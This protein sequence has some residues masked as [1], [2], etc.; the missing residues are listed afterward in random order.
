MENQITQE[1]YDELQRQLA[2][3]RQKVEVLTTLNATDALTGIENHR[4]FNEDLKKEIGNSRRNRRKLI[5]IMFDVDY[6]KDINDTGGHIWGD[7]V[8]IEMTKAVNST[9]RDEDSFARRS[10]DEFYLLFPEESTTDLSHFNMDRY[11]EAIAK[12][13]RSKDGEFK[14]LTISIGA[15]II[16]FSHADP[17]N[18]DQNINPERLLEEVDSFLYTSKREGRDRLSTKTIVA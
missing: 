18:P 17:N 1:M 5:L 13:N 6:F 3:E 15:I 11:R 7:K 12:I 2:D 8:L 10:G 14:P 9:K 16:D 4:A